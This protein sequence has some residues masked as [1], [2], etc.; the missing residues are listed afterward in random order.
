[1]RSAWNSKSRTA[2][3]PNCVLIATDDLNRAHPLPL[4][5]QKGE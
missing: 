2:R 3:H 5:V 1:M 4:L